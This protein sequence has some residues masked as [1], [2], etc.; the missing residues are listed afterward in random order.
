MHRRFLSSLSHAFRGIRLVWKEEQNFRI[1]SAVALL[2]TVALLAFGFSYSESAI[3]IFA[4]ML[5]LGG[6]MFNTLVEN[7]LDVIE[8]RHHASV[9]KM[10]DMMAGVVLLLSVGAAVVGALVFL[11]HFE[12]PVAR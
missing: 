4:M 12:I 9:G 7:L 1:Q 5:V 8:P 11:H 6:E 3:I 10:K 2:V